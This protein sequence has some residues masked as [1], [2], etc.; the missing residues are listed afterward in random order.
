MKQYQIRI[1]QLPFILALCTLLLGRLGYAQDDK[2]SMVRIALSAEPVKREYVLGEP[3]VMKVKM[4]NWLGPR[5]LLSTNL[6]LKA[7][8][9]ILRIIKKGRPG[10]IY[11][12]FYEG[13]APLTEK[14]YM[15]GYGQAIQSHY[16]V[17]YD[18]DDEQGLAL[19]QPGPYRF[20]INQEIYALNT[21]LPNPLRERKVVTD[22]SEEITVVEPSGRNRE[23][24]ELLKKTPICFRDL[25]RQIASYASIH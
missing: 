18:K 25:N 16:T 11:R 12:A 17:L 24:F 9:T 13:A 20:Q 14:E 15:L 6:D 4:R 2:K 8:S 19:A 1:N 10:D 23:A 21:Y 5:V 22:I 7:E 3:V